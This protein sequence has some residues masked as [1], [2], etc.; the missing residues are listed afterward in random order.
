MHWIIAPGFAL[1][2]VV[3]I[4]VAIPDVT[5]LR[6]LAIV[7][8]FTGTLGIAMLPAFR[9]IAAGAADNPENGFILS[10]LGLTFG[11]GLCKQVAKAI[12]LL[13]LARANGKKLVP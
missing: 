11:V 5:R 8:A 6:T 3:M 12:P 2:F 9:F 7:A 1:A 13:F 10:F 4:A